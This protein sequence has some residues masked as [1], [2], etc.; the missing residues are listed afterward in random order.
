METQSHP[1]RA[2]LR[3]RNTGE[4]PV[5]V[6][7]E[8]VCSTNWPPRLTD[9]PRKPLT[10]WRQCCKGRGV[11]TDYVWAVDKQ[12]IPE[13][14]PTFLTS[15]LLPHLHLP[16]LPAEREEVCRFTA[17]SDADPGV[18]LGETLKDPPPPCYL[19]WDTLQAKCSLHPWAPPELEDAPTLLPTSPHPAGFTLTFTLFQGSL[20]LHNGLEVWTC[21]AVC[22]RSTGCKN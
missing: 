21:A 16:L 2:L 19:S 15:S 20:L 4:T 18:L 1:P 3:W 7:Q 8:G 13:T 5:L 14:V 10:G 11:K 22:P 17:P 9:A 12:I 6:G